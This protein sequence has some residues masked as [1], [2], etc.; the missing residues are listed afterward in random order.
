MNLYPYGGGEVECVCVCV[1]VCVYMSVNGLGGCVNREKERGSQY[2]KTEKTCS[3]IKGTCVRY[4]QK[5]SE[6]EGE[7]NGRCWILR[8][9]GLIF[10]GFPLGVDI[11]MIY[12]SLFVWIYTR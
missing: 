8:I 11:C 9:N 2:N 4:V 5:R 1:C 3:N 7:S 6:S 12:L 10:E